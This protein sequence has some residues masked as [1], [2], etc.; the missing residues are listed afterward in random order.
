MVETQAQS[1]ISSV[2]S[3]Q[4]QLVLPDAL[5]SFFFYIFIYCPNRLYCICTG[6]GLF[7]RQL[8]E[9]AE[10]VDND[11]CVCVCVRAAGE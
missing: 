9:R 4:T 7:A 1:N 10:C 6:F 11:L 5:Y 8:Q 3:V 2:L